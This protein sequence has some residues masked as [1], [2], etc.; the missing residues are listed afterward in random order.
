M[1]VAIRSRNVSVPE[2]VRALTEEKLNR[3]DRFLD[4]M[5]RV[6]VAFREEKNPRIAAREV[7]EVSVHGHGH[8]VRAKAASF[9]QMSAVDEVVDKLKHQL[10]KTKLKLVMRKHSHKANGKSQRVRKIVKQKTFEL[11]S[12][13]PADA[14]EEMERLGHDFF[15]FTNALTGESSVVYRRSDGAVALIDST[16]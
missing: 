3:L 11:N 15:L 5:E 12:I 16:G 4:G 13:T 9:D 14:V 6:D 8:T 1:Q 7:C 2:S 10:E